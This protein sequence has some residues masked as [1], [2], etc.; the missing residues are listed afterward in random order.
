MAPEKVQVETP[1]AA[2]V[3]HRLAVVAALG[4]MM[5]YAR[6]NDAWTARHNHIVR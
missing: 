4:D 3:E 2:R 6:K 1:V 5:G